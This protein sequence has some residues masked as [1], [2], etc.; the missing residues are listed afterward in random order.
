MFTKFI[1]HIQV[2]SKANNKY[3]KV[4]VNKYFYNNYIIIKQIQNPSDFEF[5][6]LKKSLRDFLFLGL[7][8]K[9]C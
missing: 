8:S 3:F 9:N 2:F 6:Q 4:N 1:I 5:E 7:F